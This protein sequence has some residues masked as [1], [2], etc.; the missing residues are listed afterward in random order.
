MQN[1][2]AKVHY[3]QV[4]KMQKESML[5]LRK[6]ISSKRP[7]FK[8][9]DSHKKA[10]LGESWRRPRGVHSKQRHKFGGKPALI[11][12]GYRGPTLV[13]GLTKE[14]FI[15]IIVSNVKDV[16]KVKDKGGVA[17]ISSSVGG[18]KKLLIIEEA[19]KLNVS[20]SN[21]RD[22]KEFTEKYLKHRKEMATERKNRLEKKEAEKTKVEKKKEKKESIEEK[23]SKVST[24]SETKDEDEKKKEEIREAEKIMIQKEA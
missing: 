14:G 22:T 9:Y 2:C 8:R 17:I 6:A 15:P 19:S 1:G 20:I 11:S 3:A 4:I 13:R 16:A 23:I 5:K 18:R 12:Q 7:K 24:V 21:I 10:R